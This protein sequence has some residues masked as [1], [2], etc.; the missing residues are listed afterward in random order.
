ME[1]IITKDKE[2]QLETLILE[3]VTPHQRKIAFVV[4]RALTQG[5]SEFEAGS[6]IY[7]MC[8]R[9]E[10]QSYGNILKWRHSEIGLLLSADTND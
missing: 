8:V 2:N 7:M 9:G 3:T 5:F 10:L 4:A 6:K 1:E